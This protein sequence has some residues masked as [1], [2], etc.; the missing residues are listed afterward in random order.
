MRLQSAELMPGYGLTNNNGIEVISINFHSARHSSA[1]DLF[2]KNQR[3]SGRA[4]NC[5][6]HGLAFSGV[7]QQIQ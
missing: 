1:F 7:T 5:L 2:F 6:M 3:F 4:V